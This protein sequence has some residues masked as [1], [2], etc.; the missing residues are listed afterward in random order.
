MSDKPQNRRAEIEELVLEK[1]N[2]GY[3][4]RPTGVSHCGVMQT[5]WTPKVYDPNPIEV[6]IDISGDEPVE[7]PL[8][9]HLVYDT[10]VWVATLEKVNTLSPKVSSLSY[11]IDE[12][13]CW[14]LNVD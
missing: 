12:D 14:S 11:R 10:F 1:F 9:L 5:A 8:I 4:E 6:L 7:V 2:F 13:D 3:E